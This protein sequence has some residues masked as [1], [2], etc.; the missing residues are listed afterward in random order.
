MTARLRRL[1]RWSLTEARRLVQRLGLS[2]QGCF[3][4]G[5]AVIALLVAIAVLGG[6]SEDVTQHNGLAGNDPAHLR[7]FVDHRP[8]ALVHA[9][10]ITSDFGNVAILALVAIGMFALLWWRRLPVVAA[11]APAIAL[12]GAAVLA[13]AGKV[14]VDRGRPPA[15]VR[16]VVEGEPSFPSGHAAHG[17]AVYV[18]LALVLGV[19]VFRQPLLRFA[20]VAGAAVLAAAIGLSR[21]VL[22]VHW[23]SDVFAG[24]ALGAAVALGTTIAATLLVCNAPANPTPPHRRLPRAG[25]LLIRLLVLERHSGRRGARLQAA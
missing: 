12:G 15:S 6:V 1:G 24:W 17:T 4:L 2:W 20:I 16:L 22:A 23:P 9:A 13:K 3:A 8:G 19:F 5:T 18:T 21:L 11:A 25:A 7:F 10:Q 14:L